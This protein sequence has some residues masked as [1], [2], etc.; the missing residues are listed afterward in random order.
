MQNLIKE[1]NIN[2]EPSDWNTRLM[3][4][5]SFVYLRAD[6]REN[7]I[8]S[9]HSEGGTLDLYMD[10]KNTEIFNKKTLNSI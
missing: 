4:F 9:L 5:V 10:L 1:S 2:K 6:S 3:C 8:K 7:M